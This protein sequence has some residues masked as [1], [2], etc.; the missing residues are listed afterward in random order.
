MTAK[1]VPEEPVDS[2]AIPRARRPN[3]LVVLPLVLFVGLAAIFLYQLMAGGDPSEV[4]SVLIGKPAPKTVL[5]ALEGVA[6]PAGGPVK[7]LSLPGSP[8]GKPIL[9]NVFASWCAPC[10][11]EHPI[12]R[13]LAQDGRF[14]LVAI[15]YKDKPEN[16][17]TFL[18]TLG[19]PYE[20]IGVDEKG[21]STIDWG[22]YGVPETFLISADGRIVWKQTGPFTPQA[23]EN[24]LYPALKKALKGGGTAG[25]PAD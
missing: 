16:A 24:G 11:E 5:P 19:N 25:I 3:L 18:E 4:P 9:L 1:P 10:R 6:A 15:N 13:Q 22:V 8:D 14:H 7:G 23:V 20:A 21:Q 2:A 12:M 17:R